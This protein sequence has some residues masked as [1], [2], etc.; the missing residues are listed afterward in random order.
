[1]KEMK[2]SR[3]AEINKYILSRLL[4]TADHFL[5]IFDAFKVVETENHN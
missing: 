3:L 5:L 1:M 4:I 2:V